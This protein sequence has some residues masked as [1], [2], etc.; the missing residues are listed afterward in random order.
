MKKIN[1]KKLNNEILLSTADLKSYASS[2]HS[3]GSNYVINS[4]FKHTCLGAGTGAGLHDYYDD[5]MVQKKKCCTQAKCLDICRKF[6]TFVITRIGFMIL[7]IGYML[8][9]GKIIEMFEA[10]NERAALSLSNRVLEDLL[11]RIY[12][13][14]ESNTTRVRDQSFYLFLKS[15]IM[16]V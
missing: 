14:I 9:G 5:E 4:R 12:K 3:A 11:K 6:T 1:A 7:M 2:F 13:Q 8:A 10:D 15:E 16:L